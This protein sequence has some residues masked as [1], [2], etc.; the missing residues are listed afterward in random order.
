MAAESWTPEDPPRLSDHSAVVSTGTVQDWARS[1]R[2]RAQTLREQAAVHQARAA[3]LRNGVQGGPAGV[4][5]EALRERLIA[6]EAQARNLRE[7]QHS[8]RRIG[9]AIGILM[10]RHGLTEERAFAVLRQASSRRNVRLRAIAEE[11]VF[12]GMVF[13]RRP[14]ANGTAGPPQTTGAVS[15]TSPSSRTS[16]PR[17]RR[18]G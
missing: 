1:A 17:S 13:D 7:A 14:Q 2:R 18:G 3:A 15:T 5:A 16:S 10:A 6:A 9:M 4:E 8:N 11:V 12:T